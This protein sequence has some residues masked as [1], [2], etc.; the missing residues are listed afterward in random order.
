[1]LMHAKLMTLP[2]RSG[3]LANLLLSS[4]LSAQCQF[5]AVDQ[6]P[7]QVALTQA[8]MQHYG[9]SKYESGAVS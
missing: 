8:R 1:M 2:C 3:G 5:Y 4:V 6:S 9:K 7:V